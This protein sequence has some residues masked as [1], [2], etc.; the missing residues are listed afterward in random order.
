MK[1]IL[2]L[3]ALVFAFAGATYAQAPATPKGE[4][5]PQ[6]KFEKEVHDF[7]TIPEGPL[8]EYTFIFKNV[9]GAP[10][11]I[12]DVHSTGGD[13][14]TEWSKEP[15]LPGKYG[16]IKVAQF[17]QGRVGP[18]TK[19]IHVQ[20]QSIVLGHTSKWQHYELIIKGNIVKPTSPMPAGNSMMR[21]GI[22]SSQQTKSPRFQFEEEVH[23][24]GTLEAGPPAVWKFWFKNVGNTP[25]LISSVST[26]DGGSVASWSK[27]PVF[28]G[29]RF[30]CIFAR[31][32]RRAHAV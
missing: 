15:V 3:C 7:G 32:G 24:F 8:A 16:K 13:Q 10:L 9:G 26:A 11:I 17:T 21:P 22:G 23:D 27:E 30:Y 12:V 19:S 20:L 25:L 5:V 14:S 4:G 28:P 1:K 29:K 31:H 18:F 6:F 2:L